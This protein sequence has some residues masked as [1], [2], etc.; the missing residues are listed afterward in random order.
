MI[1]RYAV[2]NGCPTNA[3]DKGVRLSSFRADADGVGLASNTTLP[4][5][6]LLLPVVRLCTGVK[7][8]GDVV[9]RRLC[10]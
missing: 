7:A 4:I 8:Q 2:S 3:G 6:I 5:S 1:N 10:C 9:A